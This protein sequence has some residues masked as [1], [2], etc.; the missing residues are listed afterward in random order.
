[1]PRSA[2]H[3]WG[4]RD[5]REMTDELSLPDVVLPRATLQFRLKCWRQFQ[6]ALDPLGH[7]RPLRPP[8]LH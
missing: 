4:A 8:R 2:R 1:M 3:P 7:E 5:Q 6:R